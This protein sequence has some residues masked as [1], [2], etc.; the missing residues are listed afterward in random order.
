MALNVRQSS[1]DG[2]EK[3][4]PDDIIELNFKKISRTEKNST[5]KPRNSSLQICQKQPE[6]LPVY[7]KE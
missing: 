1:E 3:I 6:I 7:I 5:P 2:L 4:K